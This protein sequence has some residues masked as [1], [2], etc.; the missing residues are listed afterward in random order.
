MKSFVTS[1]PAEDFLA[2]LR[3]LMTSPLGRTTVCNKNVKTG[4]AIERCTREVEEPF[5]LRGP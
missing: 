3:V 5:G 1:N 4:V 2:R